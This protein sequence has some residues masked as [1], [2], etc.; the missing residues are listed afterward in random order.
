MTLALTGYSA[1]FMRYAMAVTPVNYLLFG[2]HFVNF[3]AQV[4]QG[5]RY[6][7]YW[8]YVQTLLPL[9]LI[10]GQVNANTH[11]LSF[12]GKELQDKAK[13]EA[14]NIAGQAKAAAHKVEDKAKEVANKVTSS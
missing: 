9:V 13:S 5:Y 10:T 1:T 8:K 11:V 6:L 7:N 3:G 4:T 2:C 12:G 14:S